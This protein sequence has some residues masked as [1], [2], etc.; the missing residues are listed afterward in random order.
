LKRLVVFFSILLSLCLTA[1]VFAAAY[2]A[3]FVI[4]ESNGTTYTMLGI[5]E[6]SPTTWL[7]ANGYIEADALDT[8]IETLAGLERP[9]LVA[10]DKILTAVAIPGNSQTN[11]NFT[12]GNTD[13]TSMD[14]ITGYNGY[15]TVSDAAAIELGDDG[16]LNFTDL[17]LYATGNVLSKANALLM[18]YNAGTNTLK[19]DVYKPEGWYSPTGFVDASGQWSDE[20]KAYDGN[21]ATFAFDGVDA[22]GG[23]AYSE[24]IELTIDAIQC[25]KVRTWS[26]YA[27]GVRETVQVEV[28]YEAAWHSVHNGAVNNDAWSADMNIGATKTVTALRFRQLMKAPTNANILLYEV[29]FYALEEVAASVSDVLAAEGEYDVDVV[30]DGVNM[31]LYVGGVLQDSDTVA[32]VPDNANNWIL[33]SNATPYL[34]AY[35]HSVAGTLIVQYQPQTIISGTTLPDREGAA[36]NGVI[37]WGANPAGIAVVLGSL[38]SVSQPSP[39]QTLDEPY[40]DILPAIEVSD[41]YEEPDVTGTLLTNPLRPFV[42]IMSDATSMTEMQAWR[43]LGLAFV[44]FCTVAAAVAVRSHL[45]IAGII[46]GSSIGLMVAFTIFPLWSVVFIIGAIAAGVVAE[47]S[48]S[49]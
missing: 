8:R 2:T 32:P 27:V 49:L 14:I 41:W 3:T 22:S 33:M 44:L 18:D 20:A 21:T 6:D 25:T 30:L 48:P 1:T 35:E 38:N 4:T 47:R 43:L 31:E 26:L 19:V 34:G 37:T 28:W 23:D 16:E 11:L 9:H 40:L 7:A 45:L 29:Q 42:T 39:G 12:T 17:A 5:L 46:C 10:D 24:W 15:V 13:L 36:Q